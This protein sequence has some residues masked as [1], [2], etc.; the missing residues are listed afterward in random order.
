MPSHSTRRRR[1]ARAPA[2]RAA[3]RTSGSAWGNAARRGAETGAAGGFSLSGGFAQMAAAMGLGDRTLSRGDRGEEVR[4]LQAALGFPEA[5]QDGDFGPATHAGVVAFQRQGG[6]SPDGIVGPATRA[7]LHAQAAPSGPG[8]EPGH[9]DHED[10]AGHHADDGH[11]HGDARDA[12]RQAVRTLQGATAD[13]GLVRAGASGPEVLEIQRLLG[14]TPAGQ[15][16]E[17]G[18]T[19]VDLVERFQRDSGL[20]SDGVVGPSTMAAL[21][22]ST[23][24]RA[25]DQ[26]VVFDEGAAGPGVLALQQAL[27]LSAG[28]QTG[29][30][31]PTTA[32]AVRS[33]QA[34]NN[35]QQN[36]KVGP[37]TWEA[38]KTAGAI[39]GRYL[40]KFDAY[41]YGQHIG[42]IDVVEIDGKKVAA[43]T[44]RAWQELKAA[45]A[46]DGVRLKLNSG[47]RTHGEQQALY[48]AYQ[49][50]RGNL[51]AYPGTS[52]HQHGQALDI[53]VARQDAYDWMHAHAPGL[54]WERTVSS[55][56]W[57]WE[58]LAR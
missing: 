51:A 25:V 58:Y 47:F 41:R 50:G 37:T 48:R 36:G 10:H 21:L 33:F 45:A 40:G 57:H 2:S 43:K 23:A 18:P 15:T 14:V 27:G 8:S 52:N 16:G 19:T 31:G 13:G 34:R 56:P 1:P 24:Q 28:G 5:E 55:E 6:L 49:S 53:D 12:A 38:L 11:D 22:R 39:P 7:A 3:R 4:G 35:I 26:G 46:R 9:E 30:Y 54:G 20:S 17:Y 44:A 42:K 29:E 32:Q